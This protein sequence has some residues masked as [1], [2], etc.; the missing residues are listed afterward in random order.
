MKSIFTVAML[1][2]VS[3]GGGITQ[4][5]KNQMLSCTFKNFTG[6]DCPG[7]GFQ[8]SVLALF[9]GD[10]AKSFKLY[11]PTVPLIFLAIFLI[12]HLKLDFK[13]GAITIKLMYILIATMVI[14]NYIYKVYNQQLF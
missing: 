7:C 14:I 6:V 13:L 3:E 10:F 12:L 2:V 4:W 11:P 8:R 1:L 5:L 9:N